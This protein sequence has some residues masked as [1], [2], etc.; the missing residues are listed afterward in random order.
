[1]AVWKDAD[2][3][4]ALLLLGA[5]NGSGTY[6]YGYREIKLTRGELLDPSVGTPGNTAPTSIVDNAKYTASL[7]KHSITGLIQTPSTVNSEKR[8]FAST[9]KAGLWVYDGGNDEW[10]AQD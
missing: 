3:K 7:G 6:A 10:N 2:N 5:K 1:M 4:D 9:G 8:L